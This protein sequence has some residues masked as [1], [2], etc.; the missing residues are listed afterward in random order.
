MLSNAKQGGR[1]RGWN[2]IEVLLIE[3]KEGIEERPF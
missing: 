3:V 1:E 2:E